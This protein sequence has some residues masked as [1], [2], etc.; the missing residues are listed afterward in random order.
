MI[1]QLLEDF[2]KL[3]EAGE[4]VGENAEGDEVYPINNS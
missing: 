2:N 1:L 4:E 3:E